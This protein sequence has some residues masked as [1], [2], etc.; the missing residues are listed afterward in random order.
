MDVQEKTGK[1]HVH[2]KNGPKSSCFGFFQRVDADAAGIVP[3]SKVGSRCRARA[4]ELE[5]P[6]PKTFGNDVFPENHFWFRVLLKV[7]HSQMALPLKAAPK[8]ASS[9]AFPPLPQLR[10]GDGDAA[11][12][13]VAAETA[14]E[15]SPL[16]GAAAIPANALPLLERWVGVGGSVGWVGGCKNWRFLKIWGMS[17]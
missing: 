10:E 7:L 15:R 13:G 8:A 5:T 3:G 6:V 17:S 1:L 2:S 12:D 9:S 14:A 4:K 11:A 16:Q